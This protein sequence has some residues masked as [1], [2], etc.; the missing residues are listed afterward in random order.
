MSQT[1]VRVGQKPSPLS[2]IVL[3][4]SAGPDTENREYQRIH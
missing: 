1:A 3:P 2:L 4:L